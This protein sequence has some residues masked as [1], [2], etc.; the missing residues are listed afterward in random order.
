MKRKEIAVVISTLLGI[1]IILT[2]TIIVGHWYDPSKFLGNAFVA[3]LIMRVQTFVI[4][5][6]VVY[7]G[8]KNYF[9]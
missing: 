7:D 1:V 6:L 2:P 5:L 8:I 9:K 4:G 3:D